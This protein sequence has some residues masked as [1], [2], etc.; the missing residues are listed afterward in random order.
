MAKF[1]FFLLATPFILGAVV[2]G[3]AVY[4]VVATAG[5]AE[6]GCRNPVTGE[7][8]PLLNDPGAAASFQETWDSL[9]AQALT[10][11]TAL[12]AAFNESQVT[13]RAQQ[14]LDAR[15]APLEDIA[16]CFHEGEAEAR[17]RTG[18]PHASDL[19]LFGSIFEADVKIR[20]TI[21]LTGGYPR[22][23]ISDLDA[24][25]VPGT[26]TG[27]LRHQVEDAVNPRLTDLDLV[28]EYNVIFT[29]GA[30]TVTILIVP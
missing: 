12:T 21:D 18:V 16:I 4:F 2:I 29:E 24:D 1:L 13:S 10:G 14:Y 15:D 8:R 6:E 17:A 7:V 5:G 27:R 19:P 30:A 11:Q 25:G 3:L 26:L 23:V 28:Y 20:G 9:L 22:L